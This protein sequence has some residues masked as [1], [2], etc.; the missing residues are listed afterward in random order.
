M[1][2]IAPNETIHGDTR[3]P[4][5]VL[6]L[7]ISYSLLFCVNISNFLDRSVFAMQVVASAKDASSKFLSFT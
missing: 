4:V 2:V 7:T 5:S 3:M 1:L 6:S